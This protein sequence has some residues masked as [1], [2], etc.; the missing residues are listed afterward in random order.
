MSHT[1]KQA[2]HYDLSITS[3]ERRDTS[4]SHW[5]KWLVSR[6][7]SSSHQLTW[8]GAV[9][10]RCT[11]WQNDY[12]SLARVHLFKLLHSTQSIMKPAKTGSGHI[13][14]T[15]NHKTGKEC[16]VIPHKVLQSMHQSA[17]DIQYVASSFPLLSFILSSP[18]TLRVTR[19]Q[20]PSCPETTTQ[21]EN[22]GIVLFLPTSKD[23]GEENI[24]ESNEMLVWERERKR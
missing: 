17:W 5:G 12:S 20:G 19:D 18:A 13:N 15:G 7:L 9:Q 21:W 10:D 2:G 1:Q 14:N 16:Q 8:L 3:S 6:Y 24:C 22:G 23:G 11:G 4:L